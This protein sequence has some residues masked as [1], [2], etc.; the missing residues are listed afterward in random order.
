VKPFPNEDVASYMGRLADANRLDTDALSRLI[1]GTKRVRNLP[2]DLLAVIA[3]VSS[4]TLEFAIIDIARAPAPQ[5]YVRG[6]ACQ[7]CAATKGATRPVSYWRP[8]EKVVCLHHRRW[9]GSRGG[10]P[11]LDR[12][13]A[14]IKAY[15]QH[16][17]LVKRFGREEAT[18]GFGAAINVCREWREMRQHNEGELRLLDSFH[19]PGWQ[20]TS[21]DPTVEAAVYPQVVALARLLTSPYWKTLAVEESSTGQ[22]LFARELT[23]TVAPTCRWPQP[24]ES[25]DPLY[26]WLIG[27]ELH[28]RA[29]RRTGARSLNIEPWDI[30]LTALK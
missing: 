27:N 30:L 2:L 4:Q 16:L 26:L 29:H 22:R 5:Q 18:R 15:G 9:I 10:Q 28:G 7:L 13:P 6:A 14:I 8:S 12:Q 24:S 25:K 23:R 19:G 20:L 1:T 11:S 3:A 17:R 21:D